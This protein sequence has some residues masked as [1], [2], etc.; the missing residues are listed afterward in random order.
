[1]IFKTNNVFFLIIIAFVV[2]I[3]ITCFKVPQAPEAEQGTLPVIWVS[4]SDLYFTASETGQ[5]PPSQIIQIKNFGVDTLNYSLSDDVDWSSLSQDSGSSTGNI[6]EHTVSIDKSGLQ[7]QDTEYTSTITISSSEAYNSPQTVNLH[8]TVTEEPPPEILINT[9]QMTFASQEGG[10]NPPAQTLNISNSSQGTLSYSVTSDSGWLSVSPDSGTSTVSSNEHQVSANTNGLSG[11]TYNGQLTIADANASNS[12][13]I[14]DVTLTLS[15]EP[16]PEFLVDTTSLVFNAITTGPNP[17]SEA[18]SVINTGGGTLSYSIN[19]NAAW[20][21]V[22]PTDGTSTGNDNSHSVSVDKSSLGE[23]TYYGTITITDPNAL[24]SPQRISVTLNVDPP[25]TS[26][27]IS[28]SCS[29][30]SGGTNTVVTVIIS[31]RGNTS[32]MDASGLKVNFNTAMFVFLGVDKGNLTRNWS[33]G[34]NET[35]SGVITVGGYAGGAS[36]IPTGSEGSIAVLEFRVTCSGC[37]DGAT[38]QFCI[39]NLTDDLVGMS[40]NPACVTFKFNR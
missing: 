19:G 2:F 37:T 15:T 30:A 6:N 12:P 8:L 11:G 22:S 34:G 39:T 20:F 13:Q 29:P 32:V 18:F 14:V 7:A 24:N 28:I 3:Q 40:T 5:N 31:I 21:S 1:M 4:V 36:A 35:S 25:D 9:N 23:G 26:N 27:N 17:S 38:S 10:S 33:V 16:S